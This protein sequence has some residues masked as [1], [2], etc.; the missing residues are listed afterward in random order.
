MHSILITSVGGPAAENVIRNLKLA[1]KTYVVGTDTNKYMIQL[2]SADSTELVHHASEATDMYIK[3]LNRV[4]KKYRC[5]MLMPISDREIYVASINRNRLPSMSIPNAK[6]VETCR[7]KGRLNDFLADNSV[8]RVHSIWPIK[9]PINIDEPHW[10]RAVIGAGGYL[11]HR[12]EDAEDISA[13]LHL[14][15]KSHRDFM[16][17]DYLTG[18]NYCWTSL[19]VHGKLRLSVTKERLGWVYGRIGTTAVQKT[20][21]N[22]LIDSYCESVVKS[23]IDC[24]DIDMTSLIMIDLMEDHVTKNIFVTEVNAGRTGTVSNW[25]GVASQL[26]FGDARANFH[27]Q[28]VRAHYNEALLGCQ[29]YDALPEDITYTR[30]IDMKSLLVWKNKRVKGD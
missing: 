5:T 30:H 20:V 8:P 22:V 18:K 3:D 23:L 27:H 25:F 4:A 15:R 11:A 9:K 21:H 12:V 16:L 13:V 1:E 26:V 7:H 10:M 19:W 29:K 24:Y 28:L 6:L 2:S 17:C 14:N